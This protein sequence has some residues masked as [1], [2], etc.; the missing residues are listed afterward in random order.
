MTQTR[1]Y[2]EPS[3]SEIEQAKTTV[4]HMAQIDMQEMEALFNNEPV[5]AVREGDSFIN[6]PEELENELST[7]DEFFTHLWKPCFEGLTKISGY[8]TFGMQAENRTVAN[9]MYRKIAD[10]PYLRPLLDTKNASYADLLHIGIFLVGLVGGVLAE[11]KQKK[12]EKLLMAQQK[13]EQVQEPQQQPVMTPQQ[14]EIAEEDI[15]RYDEEFAN[16]GIA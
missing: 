14:E 12:Q 3:Q 7:P 13:R 10:N 1:T 2:S 16:A 11:F 5:Q 4:D 9:I 8:Q 15:E 6:E